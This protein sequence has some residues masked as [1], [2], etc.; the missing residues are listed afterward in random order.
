MSC[1]EVQDSA[2]E[3]ALDIL[4]PSK[5]AELEAH[6]ANCEACRADVAGMCRS[7]ERLLDLDG[8]QRG[9]R[10]IRPRRRRLRLVTTLAAAAV[11][12]LGSALGPALVRTSSSQPPVASAELQQNGQPVGVVAFYSGTRPSVAVEVK[13]LSASGRLTFEALGVDGTVTRLGDFKLFSGGGSWATSSPVNSARLSAVALV[14]SHGHVVAQA[15]V[16]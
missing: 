11:L 6:L 8:Y 9:V 7:A 12:M 13:G 10:W 1:V 4:E 3:F 2:P 15:T 5:R 14:D 16:S